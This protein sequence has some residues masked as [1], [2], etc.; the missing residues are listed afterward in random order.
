MS[1]RVSVPA[2]WASTGGPPNLD[3]SVSKPHCPAG[4]P[5]MGCSREQGGHATGVGKVLRKRAFQVGKGFEKNPVR[6]SLHFEN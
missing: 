4:Q 6:W 3:G 2:M 5:A 1:S